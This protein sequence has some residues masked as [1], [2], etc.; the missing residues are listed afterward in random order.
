MNKQI[1]DLSHK[2]AVHLD[3]K[4]STESI[5]EY[6]CKYFTDKS[7]ILRGNLLTD[8]SSSS[9]EEVVE[10]P[11]LLKSDLETMT[12]ANLKEICKKMNQ[13]TSGNK[14]NLVERLLDAEMTADI[15]P[16]QKMPVKIKKPKRPVVFEK[17]N[18]EVN[19]IPLPNHC[20]LLYDA[21]FKL[22]FE[23]TNPSTVIGT[24]EDG[25]IF[26]LTTSSMELCKSKGLN[27]VWPSNIAEL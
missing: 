5:K 14:A 12:I 13:K 25:H 9:D 21:E 16:P 4:D 22:V 26:G 3:L 11:K 24:Y 7:L 20:D 15:I 23:K 1:E 8:L 6:I 18:P 2:L 17:I 10:R 27:Y 19:L